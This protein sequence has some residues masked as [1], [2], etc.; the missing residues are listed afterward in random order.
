MKFNEVRWNGIVPGDPG[1]S[2]ALLRCDS[3]PVALSQ[4]ACIG[5]TMIEPLLER[6][7]AVQQANAVEVRAEVHG[8]R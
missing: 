1:N 8:K 4:V 2:A 7:S 5:A 3:F 6:Q